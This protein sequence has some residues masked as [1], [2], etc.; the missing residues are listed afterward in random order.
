MRTWILLGVVA[1]VGIGVAAWA[2]VHFLMRPEP[3]TPYSFQD[4]RMIFVV[5]PFKAPANDNEGAKVAT[6][7]TDAA[8]A[9]GESR[10][11][12]A[13]LASRKGV[14]QAVAKHTAVKDLATALNANFLI[15]GNV[16]PAASGYSVEIFVV[17]GATERVLGSKSL[18][19]GDGTLKERLREELDNAMSFMMYKG[20][21]AEVERAQGRP[22]EALDVRDLSFR[23]LVD[24]NE[25]RAQKDEKGAYAGAM[26]L[27]NRALALSPNDGVALYL[28]ASVNLCDC[29]EGWSKQVEEQRAIGAAALEKYLQRDSES[30]SMLTL[31]AKLYA[32]Q[33]KTE[34][35]LSI[36]ESALRNNPGYADAFAVKAYDLLKLGKPQEAL[37]ALN[38]ILERRDWQGQELALAA[39]VHYELD[40]YERAAQLA[41]KAQ[42]QMK[43]DELGNP[44][45]GAVGL[46]LVAAE[47]KLGR[48]PRAK[49]ALAE[50]NAAVPGV[51]TISA[52][53]KWMHPAADLAGYEPLFDGLR[54]AGVGD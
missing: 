34:E 13:Q 40:L 15:R 21:E 33:G 52:M 17:D 1:A 32:L 43:R 4:R 39:A 20:L 16:T 9:A 12:W 18:A 31:K 25:K 8:S 45:L 44:R 10:P 5:L 36:V 30:A 23:A 51:D 22:P 2:A 7:I 42:T 11:R 26:E 37:T 47:G 28:T 50:F 49:A 38:D 54:R 46:T 41:Q 27:L 3:I 29:V 53:K 24:W 19:V 48:L 35:S 6:A 14:E